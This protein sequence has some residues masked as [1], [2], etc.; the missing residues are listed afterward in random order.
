MDFA[1]GIS[2]RDCGSVTGTEAASPCES[3]PLVAGAIPGGISRLCREYF[4]YLVPRA[5][6]LWDAAAPDN[7]LVFLLVGAV[8]LL[9]IIFAYTGYTYWVFRGKVRA[10]S[11]YHD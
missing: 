5:I 3:L 10:D 8:I 4:P 11:G 2:R 9:P 7:S 1:I 6:T